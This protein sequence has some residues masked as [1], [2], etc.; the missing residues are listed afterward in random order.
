MSILHPCLWRFMHITGVSS[1]AKLLRTIGRISSIPAAWLTIS[2]HQDYGR[3]CTNSNKSIS[4]YF[5]WILNCK[6]NKPPTSEM[7]TI[8][9][10]F[11]CAKRE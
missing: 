4:V 2:V 1:G 7:I 11:Y 6:T 10:R 8:P 5:K 3:N 9:T